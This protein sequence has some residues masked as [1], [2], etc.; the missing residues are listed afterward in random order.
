[1]MAG[2]RTRHADVRLNGK[3]YRRRREPLGAAAAA[4]HLGVGDGQLVTDR[5][6]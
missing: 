5:L 1:M 6:Q 4:L 3:F 2:I